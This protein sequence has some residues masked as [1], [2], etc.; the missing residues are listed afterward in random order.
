MQ[1]SRREFLTTCAAAGVAGA[2]VPAFG[3]DA[4]GKAMRKYHLSI[5]PDALDADPALLEIVRTA[6]VTD[7]WLTGFLYGHWYYPLEKTQVWRR[8]VE[9]AGLAAHVINVP[10]GHPGDSL[11]ATSGDVPLTPP[12]R[13]KPGV[14][15]DGTRY[16][17]TSLH[18]PATEENADAMRQLQAAGVR[19]VFVDDDF[20]LAQGPGV[21][22]G[23]FCDEHRQ[24][25][26][27]RGGYSDA[28][29]NELLDAVKGRSL[30]P[31]LRTWIEFTCDQLTAS[32]KAQ[33]AAAPDI[34]LGIMVMYF[35]AEKAGIRLADYVDVP[36]RVGELM[37]DDASFGPVKGKTNE[38]FSVLFHRRFAKPDLAF[39]EST[40][41]PADRL[42][43]RNMAAKLVTSTIADVRNTMFMS[44]ITPFPRTH[45]EALG[46]AMKRHAAVHEKLAGHAP[47]GPFKHFWG[48]HGRCV[49]DDNAFSLFL[50]AGVPFEVVDAPG[51]DGWTFL[52][53]ADARAGAAGA[54]RS[55][56]TAFVIRSEA[57]IL[58]EGIRTMPE[59]LP[60]LFAFKKD[61]L[62]QLGGV[63]FIEEE[64]PVVCAWYPT[65]RAALLWNLSEQPETF[66]LRFGEARRTVTVAAL[67]LALAEELTPR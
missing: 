22:G 62:P 16:A 57:A 11:G 56:G 59:T 37:F 43:A 46:P 31:V 55:S 63:P 8:R 53:D 45:W 47:R 15:P 6:G 39:S 52:A 23:C 5:A 61:I 9:D 44:G 33:Q 30:A 21:I 20:R 60:A 13:W 25:F 7:L 40:A 65:A 51:K 50:A 18:A 24:A 26:L 29:W 3:S 64:K 38:L 58:W 67:D 48:E 28:Q 32:F 27:K 10:L 54:F 14:R 49:S 41:F 34:Q 4:V 1:I 36:F 19:R 2:C 42:S 12:K 35:G 17:G 66:T